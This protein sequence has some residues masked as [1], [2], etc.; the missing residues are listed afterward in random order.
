MKKHIIT[1]IIAVLAL[2]SCDIETSG[3]G[4]LDG[5]WHLERVDTLASGGSMDLS[6]EHIFWGVQYNLISADDTE[7]GSYG[8]YYMRFRQTSDSLYITSVYANHWHEDNATDSIG[9]DVPVVEINND[10]R[11][12][13]INDI[14]EQFAKEKLDGSKMVLRSKLLR[15]TLRRF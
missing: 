4:K 8:S 10:I 3:N 5:F 11:H 2:V 7:N 15:L 12:F 9:G 6:S 14:P 1:M 13:G